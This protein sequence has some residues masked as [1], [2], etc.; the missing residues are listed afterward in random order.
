MNATIYTFHRVEDHRIMATAEPH[1]LQHV[2]A[3]LADLATGSGD[4]T[5]RFYIHN[6]RG[7]V[8]AGLCRHGQWHDIL[9]DDYRQFDTNARADRTAMGYDNDERPEDGQ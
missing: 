6:G 4:E 9:R 5:R 3:H 7:V 8:G 1:N 2:A